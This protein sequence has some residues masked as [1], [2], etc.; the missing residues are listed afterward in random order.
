M[1]VDLE[2][3]ALGVGRSIWDGQEVAAEL[4][5]KR[6]ARGEAVEERGFRLMLDTDCR[7]GLAGTE[8]GRAAAATATAGVFEDIPEC[9]GSGKFDNEPLESG[10]ATFWWCGEDGAISDEAEAETVSG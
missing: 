2:N 1:D 10:E 6:V 9:G 3:L 7:A 4:W 5:E 8:G